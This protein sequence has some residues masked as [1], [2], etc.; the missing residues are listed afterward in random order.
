M[1]NMTESNPA[2]ECIRLEKAFGKKVALRDINLR[3]DKGTVLAIVGP[4]GAGKTTMLKILAGLTPPSGGRA[5][6]CGCDAVEN[7]VRLRKRIGFAPSEERSFFWRLT[8]RE[9]LRFFAALH[10]IHG[11]ESRKRIAALM[12]RVGLETKGRKKFQEYSSGM[13]QVLGLARALLHDPAVLLLD[14][15]TRSLS[16]DVARSIRVLIRQKVRGEGKSVLVASHNLREV[17]ELADRIAI[18]CEGEIRATGSPAELKERA[19]V[20]RTGDLEEVYDH[21]TRGDGGSR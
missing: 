8:G 9:N 13:K 15:P 7:A 4:S 6:V 19:G 2:V 3:T 16:P 17:E 10:G 5:L 20:A 18:L 12:E 11:H 14:E 1:I 21:F